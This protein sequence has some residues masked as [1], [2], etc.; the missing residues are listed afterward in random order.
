MMD[1]NKVYDD[2]RAMSSADRQKNIPEHRREF[3]VQK[4]EESK[5]RMRCALAV[6]EETIPQDSPLRY[7]GSRIEGKDIEQAISYLEKL[8]PV[9]K[10]NWPLHLHV[11]RVGEFAR[12]LGEQLKSN[13]SEAAAEFADLDPRTL[14]VQGLFHD[15]GKVAGQ[16]GYLRT[17]YEGDA[18]LKRS[19]MKHLAVDTVRLGRRFLPLEKLKAEVK[20]IMYADICGGVDTKDPSRITTYEE[21]LRYHEASRT[22]KNYSEFNGLMPAFA[23]EIHGLLELD[24]GD[25]ER[26]TA[27]YKELDAYFQSLGIDREK[28]RQDIMHDEQSQS[29]RPGDAL[30]NFLNQAQS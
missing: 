4:R 1:Y 28:I 9:T 8:G 12:R 16:F 7:P 13:P 5:N 3:L 21:R 24:K 27:L 2:L 6:T 17:E 10:N 29:A 23:S 18:I 30:Q 19:G 11:R 15:I 14:Q 26:Y 25:K 20:V 22:L